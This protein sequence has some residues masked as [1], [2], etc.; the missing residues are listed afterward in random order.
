M[1]GYA[2]GETSNPSYEEVSR[3]TTGHA[4][5]IQITF[6]PTVIPYEKLLEV[7]WRTHDPTTVNRQGPDTGPQYRSVIFTHSED[8]QRVAVASK[9][10][11]KKSGRYRDP[12][13]TEIIPFT[14]F[15]PAEEYHQDFYAKNPAYGYCQLIIDPK[16]EK[17]KKEFPDDVKRN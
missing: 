13:V 10:H 14:N 16:I 8:Q 4:E 3:G 7:F 1:S 9:E 2:G 11:L 15:Y 6:D 17:L 12:I 5:A